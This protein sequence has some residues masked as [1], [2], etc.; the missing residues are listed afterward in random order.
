MT[1]ANAAQPVEELRA[2][3][4]SPTSSRTSA[5][6]SAP[7]ETVTIENQDAR[8]TFSSH[9]GGLKLVELKDYPATIECRKRNATNV[10]QLA[11][12]NS[13]APDPFSLYE[14]ARAWRKMESI[15]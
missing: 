7:E 5:A 13:G 14:A 6:A 4:S 3:A 2:K 12:L 10:H 15:N 8:Y 1:N 11:T 9:G